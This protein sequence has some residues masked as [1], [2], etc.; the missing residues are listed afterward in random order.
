MRFH[1][2]GL[3]HTRTTQEYSVCA[4]TQKIRHLCQ[5]LYQ[6]GHTVYHYGVAGGTPMATEHVEVVDEET[7]QRVHGAYDYKAGDFLINRDNDA[8]RMFAERSIA[9]IGRIAQPG[10]FLLC[11]FG[12]DHQPI[13]AALPQLIAVESGIGYPDTF[14]RWR[15]FESYAWMNFHYGLEK[16]HATPNWYD[17]VIPNAFDV[18][19]FP[20]KTVK[21]PYHIFLGRPIETKG[22]AIAIQVCTELGIPLYVAGQGDQAVPEGVT[23]LGVLGI[24][25]RGKWLSEAAALWCPTY[26]IE[27]FGGVAVEAQLCGTPVI[28]TD[29]GAFP[30]TVEH[31]IT[32]YRCRTY[33]HFVW[34]A[35][36]IHKLGGPL[37][38][39]HASQHYS[40]AAV[41]P[42]YEEYFDMLAR[43]HTDGAGWYARNDAR[44]SL[45]WL[46]R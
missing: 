2:L 22:R 9:Q 32:G 17:A 29:M 43:L 8:Y 28:C 6:R 26:Y 24:K 7:F 44:R 12:L 30:E 4:F 35:R 38:S 39:I 23:H 33:E 20:C 19:D 13:A 36:N 10:D 11:T 14:A 21:K 31:G 18:N 42:M 27:P 15:V 40:L 34:A 16:R 37:C 45:G 5:M 1:V 25:E 3:S 46:E 41:A